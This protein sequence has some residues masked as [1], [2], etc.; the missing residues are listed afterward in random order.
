MCWQRQ[1]VDGFARGDGPIAAGALTHVNAVSAGGDL[2]SGVMNGAVTELDGRGLE[3]PGPLQLALIGV[4][5]LAPGQM[6]RLR[7]DRRPLLLEARLSSLGFAWEGEELA[8][9]SHVTT[10]RCA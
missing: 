3:P 6:L 10:I 1:V 9:G 5:R 4:A 7:T 8:D 2:S